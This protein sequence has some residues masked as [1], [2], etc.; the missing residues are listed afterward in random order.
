MLVYVDSSL[1]PLA[2]HFVPLTDINPY[3]RTKQAS[4]STYVQ[5]KQFVN[6]ELVW[7]C[8][9]CL[10]ADQLFLLLQHAL[11]TQ[12][13]HHGTTVRCLDYSTEFFVSWTLNSIIQFRTTVKFIWVLITFL[14]LNYNVI[15]NIF[16]ITQLVYEEV[17]ELVFTTHFVFLQWHIAK[18]MSVKKFVTSWY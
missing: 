17:F 14:L 15:Y 18:D 11:Q 6:N 5:V 13:T 3:L 1:H 16:W 2:F 12:Q 4:N 8:H 10:S 7:R 9:H